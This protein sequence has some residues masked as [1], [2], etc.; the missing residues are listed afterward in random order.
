MH[1]KKDSTIAKTPLTAEELAKKEWR[2][3]SD[4]GWDASK[5]KAL[6]PKLKDSR[7][8][9]ELKSM[10]KRCE[11]VQQIEKQA[12]KLPTNKALTSTLITQC[13]LIKTVDNG[14]TV[15]YQIGEFSYLCE[16]NTV[17]VTKKSRNS[18]VN[19]AFYTYKSDD[20]ALN[21]GWKMAKRQETVENEVLNQQKQAVKST[22]AI[23]KKQRSTKKVTVTA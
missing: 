3:I 4:I 13:G 21:A 12:N 5:L 14:S 17:I 15:D 2:L 18:I 19:I 6:L 16:D 23:A 20:E 22:L 9:Q 8:I 1:S 7:N 11:G 10:L